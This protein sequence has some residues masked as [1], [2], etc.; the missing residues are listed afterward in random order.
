M[1]KSKSNDNIYLAFSRMTENLPASPFTLLA[2]LQHKN[3]AALVEATQCAL[4]GVQRAL[5]QQSELV[6][7]LVQDNARLVGDL[8]QQADPQE[9]LNSQ[10]ELMLHSCE[11]AA[12]NGRAVR[13]TLMETEQAAAD[14]LVARLTESLAD[15]E[16]SLTRGGQK[17]VSKAG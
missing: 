4:Q 11:R 12:Q 6:M 15:L 14:I 17:K 16:G 2:Q 8:L 10:A 7:R 13:Q 1:E 3:G 9:R 5:G